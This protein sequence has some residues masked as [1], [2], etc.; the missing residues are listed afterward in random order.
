VKQEE[1]GSRAWR[2]K[3]TSFVPRHAANLRKHWYILRH[4]GSPCPTTNG[5]KS[6]GKS[7]ISGL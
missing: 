1:T 2:F 4:V 5:F 7:K 3:R 6:G